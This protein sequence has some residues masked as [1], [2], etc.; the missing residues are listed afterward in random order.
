MR[1]ELS[2]ESILLISV[3]TEGFL[4]KYL[5]LFV[6]VMLQPAEDETHQCSTVKFRGR[7][8]KRKFRRETKGAI[9]H[10]SLFSAS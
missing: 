8:S 3:H 6:P 9:E 10:L 2:T 7:G 4:Q 5:C 1:S